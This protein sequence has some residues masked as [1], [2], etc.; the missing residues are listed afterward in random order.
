MEYEDYQ[1]RNDE[2]ALEKSEEYKAIE[3]ASKDRMREIIE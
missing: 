2:M 1:K 3:K